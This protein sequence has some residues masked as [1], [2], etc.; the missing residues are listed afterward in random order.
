MLDAEVD[1]ELY[2]HV[3]E[4]ARQKYGWDEGLPVKF[5]LENLVGTDAP[6]RYSV[7]RKSSPSCSPKK[8]T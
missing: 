4:L 2:L 5:K 7:T 3:R 1:R 6:P 8:E